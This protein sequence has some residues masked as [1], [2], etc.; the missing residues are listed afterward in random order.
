MSQDPNKS[1]AQGLEDTLSEAGV[2]AEQKE[3]IAE[4]LGG[5]IYLNVLDRLYQEIP[6]DKREDFI[7]N[8]PEDPKK[9]VSYFEN[10]IPHE[11]L[12][13][14]VKICTQDILDKFVDR[15]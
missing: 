11:K 2:S 3:K 5:A 7:K 10:F 13:A 12:V 4:D 6:Q 1:I 8:L 14:I 9:T 15:L